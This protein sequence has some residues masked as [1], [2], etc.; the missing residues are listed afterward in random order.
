MTSTNTPLLSITGTVHTLGDLGADALALVPPGSPGAVL[1]LADGRHVVLWGLTTDEARALGEAFM[2]YP[3]Q[4]VV[5]P[6][7]GGGHAS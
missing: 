6:A 4:V 5:S 2:A 7:S 3:I 1:R